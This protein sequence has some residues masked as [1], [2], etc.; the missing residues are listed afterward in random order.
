MQLPVGKQNTLLDEKYFIVGLDLDTMDLELDEIKKLTK[1]NIKNITSN[2]RG[3]LRRMYLFKT[4]ENYAKDCATRHQQTFILQLGEHHP[5]LG[6]KALLINVK[7]NT[8][9][10][11]GHLQKVGK[12]EAERADSWLYDCSDGS[13]FLV[14]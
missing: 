6:R 11:L 8:L 14:K 9:K 5:T 13:Y 7:D 10:D 4:Q 1:H 3:E 12:K 2:S